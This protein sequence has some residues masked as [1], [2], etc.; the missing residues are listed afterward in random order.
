[1]DTV[2][3]LWH[4]HVL[5]DENEDIKLIGVYR[6]S[7]DAEEA[8]ARVGSKPGFAKHPEGFLIEPFELNQDH[9][10]EGYVVV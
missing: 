1:M 10:T 9:W 4:T 8:Q 5:A 6:S 2:F 7:E 3:L